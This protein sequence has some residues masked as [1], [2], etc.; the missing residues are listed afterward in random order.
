MPTPITSVSQLDPNGTY[1]YAD[2]LTWQF[3][4][5]LELLRSKVVYRFPPEGKNQLA[6][7]LCTLAKRS[8]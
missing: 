4:E 2:Y 5:L 3:S 7:S 8:L 6:F 1:T